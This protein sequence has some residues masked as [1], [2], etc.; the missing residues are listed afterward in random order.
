MIA[1]FRSRSGSWMDSLLSWWRSRAPE[2]G[3][4]PVRP[5]ALPMPLPDGIDA[6]DVLA[7]ET[8]LR[9]YLAFAL[10]D[11][12][13]EL[14]TQRLSREA[15][16]I[17]SAAATTLGELHARPELIPRRPSLLPKLMRAVSDG[18]TSLRQIAVIIGQDAALTGNLLRVANSTFYR[19]SSRSIDSIDR[20]VT[21]VGTEGIRSIITT[22]LVQPVM[23]VGHGAFARFPEIVW[24]HT[25]YASTAAET[26][27]RNVEGSE[28]FP[29]QLLALLQGL[30]TNVVFRAAREHGAAEMPAAESAPAIAA[31]IDQWTD[32]TALRIAGNWEL[33]ESVHHAFEAQALGESLPLTRAARFGRLAGSLLVLAREARWSAAAARVTALVG[34]E[35]REQ[36]ARVW[37]RLAG[38]YLH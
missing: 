22:A 1:A 25:L 21:M 14:L 18:D 5:L 9:Q 29:A 6:P 23:S 19:V 16:A 37:D 7:P 17:V 4:A 38:A 28:P 34:E 8:A 12:P 20:A 33:P 2:S 15:R 11:S 36:A 10:D 13:A 30:A 3:P 35:R 31:L 27:A 26:H 24:E 32:L